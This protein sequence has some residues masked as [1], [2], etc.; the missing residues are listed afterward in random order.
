MTN[1]LDDYQKPLDAYQTQSER[2]TSAADI[3]P[4]HKDSAER[5]LNLIR[6]LRAMLDRHA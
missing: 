2:I 4:K 5:G 1:H 3:S 6:E